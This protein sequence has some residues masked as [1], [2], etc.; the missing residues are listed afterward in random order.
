VNS[1]ALTLN[2]Q[3]APTQRAETPYLKLEIAPQVPAVVPMSVVREV[4]QLPLKR[5]TP[6]PHMPPYALGLMYR[7]AQVLWAIDLARFLSLGTLDP[8]VYDQTFVVLRVGAIS[9][10]IGVHQVQGTTW[11][12]TE[13]IQPAMRYTNPAITPYLNGCTLKDQEVLLVIDIEAI[14][15]STASESY[16]PNA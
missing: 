11:L 12:L 3:L 14:V 7:H 15:Q 1:S 16:V 6:I 8:R 2:S 4:I 13:E 10:A 5:L 9:F